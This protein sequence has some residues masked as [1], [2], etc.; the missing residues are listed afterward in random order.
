MTVPSFFRCRLVTG[1]PCSANLAR[2][3]GEEHWDVLGRMDVPERHLQELVPRV[4]VVADGRVV[5]G[6][7]HAGSS[8]PRATW[9]AGSSR[10]AAGA[11]PRT[12]AGSRPRAGPRRRRLIRRA[13]FCARSS[14]RRRKLRRRAPRIM[15]ATAQEPRR[16]TPRRRDPAGRPSDHH[17]REPAEQRPSRHEGQPP[18]GKQEGARADHDQGQHQALQGVGEHE[19]VDEHDQGRDGRRSRRRTG[20]PIARERLRFR[21]RPGRSGRR[22]PRKRRPRRRRAAPPPSRACRARPRAPPG[23]RPDPG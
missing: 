18:E 5:D 19:E 2:E 23:G 10:R 12:G 8:A 20:G 6:Q 15:A 4:T 16:V 22:G 9:A 17:D 21:E 11:T 3:V 13:S 1:T 7:E 14:S